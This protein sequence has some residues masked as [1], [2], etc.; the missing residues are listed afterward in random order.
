MSSQEFSETA[1]NIFARE[2]EIPVHLIRVA[3]SF[4]APVIQKRQR[5]RGQL[6]LLKEKSKEAATKLKDLPV[7]QKVK[8][9]VDSVDF[10]ANEKQKYGF[11]SAGIIVIFLLL[12]VLFNAVSGMFSGGGFASDEYAQKVKQAQTLVSESANLKA[13]HDAFTSNM[14]QAEALLAELRTAQK[15]LPDVQKIQGDIDAYKKEVYG[16]ETIDLNGRTSLVPFGETGFVPM[17][18]FEIANKLLIIGKTGIIADYVRDTPLPEIIAYPNQE[19]A[20]DSVIND[21]GVPY[22][23][24]EN[25]K[26]MTLRQG[27]VSLVKVAGQEA[28]ESGN[29][30]KSYNG[31][32]YAVNTEQN[33]IYRYK[34]SANGFSQKVNVL[35]ALSI[36]KILDIAVD[37]GFYVLT[38]D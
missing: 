3:H 26:L 7:L 2:I 17:N 15:Y 19:T 14:K 33:Q 12:Y 4:K 34:P 18:V 27:T 31:N 30:I 23:V 38:A 32:L 29:Q 16:I 24:S 1:K 20:L 5:G 25:T 8:E 22:I 11:I 36:S 6:D 21:S 37:G 9:K 28:W 10:G 13:N 35:P